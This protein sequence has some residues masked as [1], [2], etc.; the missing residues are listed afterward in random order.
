M[1]S[2]QASCLAIRLPAPRHKFWCNK[3]VVS[4]DAI[5]A[6]HAQVEKAVRPHHR[7]PSPP[8]GSTK[9]APNESPEIESRW[10]RRAALPSGL[11]ATL[12]KAYLR[13]K[14][15]M[16]ATCM[17]RNG[18]DRVFRSA[19]HVHVCGRLQLRVL[20][21]VAQQDDTRQSRQVGG[22]GIVSYGQSLVLVITSMGDLAPLKQP[23]LLLSGLCRLL[24]TVDSWVVC[25]WRWNRHV[26]VLLT[27]VEGEALSFPL[28][29]H[30][31]NGT[32]SS[33]VKSM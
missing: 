20:V 16:T 9:C 17:R 5:A 13:T 7:Q 12:A 30:A 1:A 8:T 19:S 24:Y 25:I 18:S 14:S 4:S 27:S 28:Q 21:G 32:T 11:T 31:E 10:P 3:H 23:E 29:K 15:N 22:R 6:S 26:P 2:S 33:D